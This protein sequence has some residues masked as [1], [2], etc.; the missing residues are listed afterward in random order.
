MSLTELERQAL[1][2]IADG[3]LDRTGAT[4]ESHDLVAA[5]RQAVNHVAAHTAKPDEAKLHIY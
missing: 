2:A 5:T 3:L 4:V 1:G